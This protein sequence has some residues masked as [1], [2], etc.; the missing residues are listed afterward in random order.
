MCTTCAYVCVEFKILITA[1]AQVECAWVCTS[2]VNP[3][4]GNM[5][6]ENVCL[7]GCDVINFEIDLIFLIELFFYMTKKSNK[8]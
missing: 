8:N 4:L 6:I 3:V 2:N 7:P 1:H 5:C